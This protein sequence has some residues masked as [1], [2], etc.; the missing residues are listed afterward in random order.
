MRELGYYNGK[1]L[2]S[3]LAGDNEGYKARAISRGIKIIARTYHLSG[4]S[5]IPYDLEGRDIERWFSIERRPAIIISG[6]T[7]TTN[8]ELPISNLFSQIISEEKLGAGKAK[9]IWLEKDSMNIKIPLYSFPINLPLPP[10]QISLE[11]ESSNVMNHYIGWLSGYF[12]P[13][14]SKSSLVR[15]DT[16]HEVAKIDSPW[17]NFEP[18]ALARYLKSMEE[19]FEMYPY[20]G[21]S[22][23]EVIQSRLSKV[24]IGLRKGDLYCSILSVKAFLFL[25][26]GDEKSAKKIYKTIL[27]DRGFSA[28]QKQIAAKN[29]GTIELE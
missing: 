8:I 29:L 12:H 23:V 22:Q 25:E 2:I 9:D 11:G 4:P 7:D 19:V 14:L 1:V 21:D 28:R 5:L 16:I 26:K 6:S 18:R 3:K 20:F 10:S 15:Q 17:K 24:L 13:D 27:R